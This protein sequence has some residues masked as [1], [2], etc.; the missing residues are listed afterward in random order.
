MV[1]T[2]SGKLIISCRKVPCTVLETS[3]LSFAIFNPTCEK[4]HHIDA[5]PETRGERRTAAN[6]SNAIGTPCS[7]FYVQHV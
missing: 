1:S 5:I 2:Q 6:D 4:S 7:I 3:K